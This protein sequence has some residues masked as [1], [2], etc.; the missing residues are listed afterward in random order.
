MAKFDPYSISSKERSKLLDEF[1]SLVVSLKTKQQIINF[2]KDLLTPSESVMLARRIQIAKMLLGGDDYEEIRR[3]LKVGVGTIINVQRWLKDGFGGY[4][5]ALEKALK[6][7]EAKEEAE[8]AKDADPHSI[9]GL[10]HNYPLYFGLTYELY[11]MFKG[12]GEE[13]RGRKKGKRK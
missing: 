3:Q 11:K 13:K 4:M 12:H 6:R 9:Q 1:Y 7:E 10:A 8:A 5:K 2:F